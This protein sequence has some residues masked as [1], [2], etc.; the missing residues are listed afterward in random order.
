[1]HHMSSIYKYYTGIIMQFNFKSIQHT[2]I[3]CHTL[4]LGNLLMTACKYNLLFT[5]SSSHEKK[6]VKLNPEPR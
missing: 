5:K 6:P 4:I 2:I 1:M 3:K